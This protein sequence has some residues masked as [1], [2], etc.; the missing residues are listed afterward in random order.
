MP[1]FA[2][3]A[4]PTAVRQTFTYKIPKSLGAEIELGKRVWVPFRSHFAI[5]I[6][7]SIH[8]EKPKFETKEIREVLGSTP[9]LSNELLQLTNWVHRFYFCSY[10][11][12]I[13]AALPLGH[14]FVSKKNLKIND[15][16]IQ[17]ILSVPEQSIIDDIKNEESVTID[18]AKKGGQVH[19]STKYLNIFSKVER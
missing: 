16:K 7:V 11:E 12:A 18:A 9:V 13:Q 15:A 5:G 2:E 4:F 1:L 3:I 8:D 19:H 14:N 6:I 10:G 17:R